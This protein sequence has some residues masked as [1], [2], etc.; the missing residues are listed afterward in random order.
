MVDDGYAG[1]RLDQEAAV[2]C[3]CGKGC[4]QKLLGCRQVGHRLVFTVVAATGEAIMLVKLEVEIL[5][6][7]FQ[8]G[9]CREVVVHPV[10]DGDGAL[11][12]FTF[13]QPTGQFVAHFFEGA[14]GLR[15][16]LEDLN[17]MPAEVT[18]QRLAHLTFVQGKDRVGKCRWQFALGDQA[19]IDDRGP[20]RVG[21]GVKRIAFAY[22][23]IGLLRTFFIVEK[24]LLN[25]A[26]LRI[27]EVLPPLLVGLPKL[28][29]F[30][31]HLLPEPA[32]VDVQPGELAEFRCL[33]ALDLL[34][35]E[36]EQLLGQVRGDRLATTGDL[37]V[38]DRDLDLALTPLR[39]DEPTV[40]GETVTVVGYGHSGDP[41]V[42]RHLR[43][44]VRII[45]VGSDDQGGDGAGVALE[46]GGLRG[47][48]MNAVVAATSRSRRSGATPGRRSCSRRTP[49]ASS[50]STPA[51][52]SSSRSSSAGG[53]VTAEISQLRSTENCK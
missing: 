5:G 6:G 37:L 17:Q 36:G 50:R 45:D 11:D 42:N 10:G 4:L 49:S 18:L 30:E 19:E 26:A 41:V 46:Q 12:R 51:S 35:V 15:F 38:L 22:Q 40:A 29:L 47:C 13:G 8:R 28:L 39:L 23:L 25:R 3:G 14:D 2:A 1:F 52:Q 7:L 48:L 27:L 43:S 34:L 53:G 33:E 44:G 20:L 24:H 9:A 16:Y 21:D 32:R 31:D